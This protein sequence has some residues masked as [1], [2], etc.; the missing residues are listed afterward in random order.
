MG[1]GDQISIIENKWTDHKLY[2]EWMQEC[3]EPAT[4]FQLRGEFRL[5]IFNSHA[6]NILIELHS[7]P[8]LKRLSVSVY[9]FISFICYSRS[10]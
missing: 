2:M 8:E 6:S 7:L 9:Y 10:M 3:F 5:L 4:A 1:P